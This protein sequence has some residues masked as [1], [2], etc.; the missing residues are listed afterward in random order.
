MRLWVFKKATQQQ[1]THNME[2]IS[3]ATLNASDR[4]SLEQV[5]NAS[6]SVASGQ[7]HTFLTNR[8]LSVILPAYNEEGVIAET[9]R[10][11]VE[12]LTPWVAD[13][14]VIVVNDGS[15]D[16]TRTIVE[17][18]AQSD[19]HVRLITH[20][21]NQ[22]Y[23]AA[24]VT[25]FEAVTRD[26]AFFTDSDGQF[27]L[28]DLEPF[29]PL[30]EQYDAVLGYRLN[31]QDTWMRKLNA[32]GW[33]T[34]VTT[35]FGVHVRDIDCA[36]KLYRA[37]FFRQNRLETRGAM[38]NAE[39]LYKL[40]RC[41]CTCTEVGVHH[42]PRISGKATGAKLSVILRALREMFFYARKWRREEL[43]QREFS[44]VEA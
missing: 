10:S 9:V 34:L 27:N 17:T 8:C 23:G 36:F 5:A 2:G 16:N 43:P 39:I 35:I 40:K 12:V 41:G 42:Y 14:E 24:L 1:R 29:F 25:G 33:H 28:R 6:Q 3:M 44:N 22:G 11:V 7:A 19:P 30:I 4:E 20:E 37:D 32:W 15:K 13:F 31:R 18:I 26:L 38:I 21:V